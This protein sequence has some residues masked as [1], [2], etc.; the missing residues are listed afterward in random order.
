MSMVVA[1]NLA[2]INANKNL[3]GTNRNLNNSLAKLSSGYRINVG[4]DAPADL[5]ISEQ[6]RA[7]SAGLERAVRNTT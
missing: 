7:Q 2:A 6:L 4:A 5:V 1:H 3:Y